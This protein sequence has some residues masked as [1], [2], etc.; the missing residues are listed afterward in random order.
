MSGDP[1][2]PAPTVGFVG[3]GQ[4]GGRI[5]VRL[6]RAGIPLVVTN[7]SPEKS[8]AVA[9]AGA[10]VLPR[11]LDVGAAVGTGIAFT[12][13]SDARAT[14]RVVLGRNGLARGLRPGS[15]VVDLSTVRPEESRTLA[16]QLRHRGIHLIDAPVGGSLDAAESG[17]L[18]FFVGGDPAHLERARSL[19]GLLGSEIHHLGPVGQ[20]SAMKLVNNLLTIG[21]IG[22]AAEALAFGE[23]LGL[24]RPQMLELLLRGGARSAMLERKRSALLDRQYDP[25][26][27]LAL[28]R[29]DLRLIELSGRA[30]SAPTRLTREVRRL[31][32]EAIAAGHGDEDFAVVLEAALAR[33]RRATPPPTAAAPPDETSGP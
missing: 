10:E 29:K 13:L 24:D 33:T 12:M 20:G 4:M 1:I 27:R 7:R 30:A 2:P 28:A 8:A 19:L 14:R 16:E 32:D 21:H 17:Q 15:L 9:A 22:L 23:R 26:F 25:R 3:L 11:P 18:L 5:A 31:V 6:A